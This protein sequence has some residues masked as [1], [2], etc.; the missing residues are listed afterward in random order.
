MCGAKQISAKCTHFEAF[1][2]AEKLMKSSFQ[3]FSPSLGCLFQENSF[4]VES[5]LLPNLQYRI[6][7]CYVPIPREFPLSFIEHGLA[8]FRKKCTGFKH[9]IMKN[10]KVRRQKNLTGLIG[11]S[12]KALGAPECIACQI[13]GFRQCKDQEVLNYDKRR[14]AHYPTRRKNKTKFN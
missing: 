1:L 13:S 12:N 10:Y 8:C 9:I 3:F 2:F 5:C 7:F 4:Q 11:P 14:K 6:L